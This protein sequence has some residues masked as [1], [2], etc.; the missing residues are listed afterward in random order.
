MKVVQK[1]ADSVSIDVEVELD[2]T[3]GSLTLTVTGDIFKSWRDESDMYRYIKESMQ[4][5]GDFSGA[6]FYDE[7]GVEVDALEY[8]EEEEEE[9]EV[10]EE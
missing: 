6:T 9:E 3:H 10:E 2:N 1:T 4:I 8:E 7:C 5:D